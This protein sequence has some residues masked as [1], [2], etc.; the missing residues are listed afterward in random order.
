MRL[1]AILR[2]MGATTIKPDTP[3]TRQRIKATA[4]VHCKVNDKSVLADSRPESRLAHLH[5]KGSAKVR[6]PRPRGRALEAVLLNTAGGLTGDDDIRWLATAGESSRLSLSTAACEKI[7]RS[8]GPPARQQTQLTVKTGARLD[9]LPQETILFNGAKLKR[10]LDINLASDAELLACEALVFGRHAMLETLTKLSLHDVWK[11]RREG[12]LIHAES[13]R[14]SGDWSAHATRRGVMHQHGASAT[15]LY[16]CR[17]NKEAL[18]LLTNSLHN[19]AIQPADQLIAGISA[20]HER[21]VVRAIAVNSYELRKF[22][23]PCI[24]VLNADMSVPAVWH[25]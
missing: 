9:W 4:E 21:I 13:F 7:Y 25:V 19:I 20:M 15:I 14:F 1:H 12:K 23:I 24:E 17:R 16:C 10:Q 3:A 22:L 6:F 5:Q 2:R 18:T 8:H 11:V